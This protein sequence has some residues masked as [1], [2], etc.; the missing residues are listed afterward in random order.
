MTRKPARPA[1]AGLPLRKVLVELEEAAYEDW[2]AGAQR[3]NRGL[4][5]FIA[6]A[7]E[8][9]ARDDLMAEIFGETGETA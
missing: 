3:R 8:T 1:K 6:E 7:L 5:D 9:I 4:S 2:L